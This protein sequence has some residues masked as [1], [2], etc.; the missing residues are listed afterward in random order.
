MVLV[1]PKTL[2]STC[3]SIPTSLFTRGENRLRVAATR[4]S[5]LQQE[6]FHDQ[7]GL[8]GFPARERGQD[9]EERGDPHPSQ[10][11]CLRGTHLG[12]SLPVC[13]ELRGRDE[14]GRLQQLQ[15]RQRV[16]QH[17]GKED[18]TLQRR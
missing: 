6:Y 5:G 16:H 4:R 2:H 17:Q 18:Q 8:D 7:N 1:W 14:F 3:T 9:D 13:A 11:S 15:Y 12:P 10:Q